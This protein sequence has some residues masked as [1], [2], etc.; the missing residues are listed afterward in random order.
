M[1]TTIYNSDSSD[2]DTSENDS[3]HAE[4]HWIYDSDTRDNESLYAK[5]Q[6]SLQQTSLAERQRVRELAHQEGKFELQ[7]IR[8]RYVRQR[9]LATQEEMFELLQLLK[10][11]KTHRKVFVAA[12]REALPQLPTDVADIL[13][14]YCDL[15]Q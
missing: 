7:Q 3:F 1:C 9:E 6:S 13:L 12:T 8:E 2:N 4:K 11:L 10:R 14:Q 15:V 5:S